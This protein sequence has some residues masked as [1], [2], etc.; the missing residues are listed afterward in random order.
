MLIAEP[1]EVDLRTFPDTREVTIMA[2]A[3]IT[4]LALLV[5]G[6]PAPGINGV[7]SAVTHEAM[8]APCTGR[9]TGDPPSVSPRAGRRR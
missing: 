2:P 6:G 7:V 1:L 3:P 4:K 9:C 5:G 8:G